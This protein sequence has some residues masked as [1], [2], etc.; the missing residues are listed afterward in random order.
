MLPLLQMSNY[1]YIWFGEKFQQ[2]QF[3]IL[4]VDFSP[5]L[6]NIWNNW[7][8][9]AYFEMAVWTLKTFALALLDASAPLKSKAQPWGWM[10]GSN[11]WRI[12]WPRFLCKCWLYL[13]G[14]HIDVF[15]QLLA[16]CSL[17][18]N[19]TM[20]SWSRSR[21]RSMSRDDQCSLNTH[22][23][24]LHLQW[25]IPPRDKN[26]RFWTHA[27]TTPMEISKHSWK[28][29]F[30]LREPLFWGGIFLILRRNFPNM[31]EDF[32]NIEEKFS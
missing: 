12:Q 18:T 2:V 7:A 15:D 20:I 22:L 28:K 6:Q 3:Q 32:P 17:G 5:N 31:E 27:W 9:G 29:R 25:R 24:V 11:S 14:W 16:L 4:T 19:D 21:S 8:I 10:T 30:C 13:F 26:A 23:K 1:S